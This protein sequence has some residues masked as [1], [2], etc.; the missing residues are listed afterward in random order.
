MK[1]SDMDID[2]QDKATALAK[3]Q[4]QLEDM[5]KSNHGADEKYQDLL[6]DL[7]KEIAER[8]S[9]YKLKLHKYILCN[10]LSKNFKILIPRKK[11]HYNPFKRKIYV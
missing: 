9:N 5:A 3:V 4:K 2:R 1:I 11:L 10:G 6:D 7:K 8:K